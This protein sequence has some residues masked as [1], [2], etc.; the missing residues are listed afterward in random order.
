MQLNSRY[1]MI[2]VG[3]LALGLPGLSQAA[4]PPSTK[5]DGTYVGSKRQTSGRGCSTVGEVTTRV[6]NGTFMWGV[7]PTVS[8]ISISSSGAI[9][10]TAGNLTV[11]GTATASGMDFD[12]TAGGCFNRWHFD[13]K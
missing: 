6:T 4:D 5:F 3:V 1:A 11:K 8:A 7:K 9:E 2:A 12:T 13:K 10:G